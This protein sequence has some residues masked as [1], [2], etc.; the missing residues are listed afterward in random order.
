MNDNYLHSTGPG[1][2]NYLKKGSANSICDQCG[3]KYKINDMK[4]QWDGLFCCYHCWDP[5]HPWLLP[6]PVIQE[7]Q[8]IPEARP[9]QTSIYTN[10][11]SSGWKSLS[12]WGGPY[13]DIHGTLNPNITGSGWT[14]IIGGPGSLTYNNKNFPINKVEE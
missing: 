9:H 11:A 7:M 8:P 2:A 6:R 12:R 13:L 10:V 1:R 14:E 3:Q 5:K 4:M